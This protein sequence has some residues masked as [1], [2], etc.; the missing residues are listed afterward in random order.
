VQT[1]RSLWP[2]HSFAVIGRMY[3][4][5]KQQAHRIVRG[6]KWKHIEHDTQT[7]AAP[8]SLASVIEV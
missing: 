2:S 1:I 8:S 6:L 7:A 3:G 5:S 4:I